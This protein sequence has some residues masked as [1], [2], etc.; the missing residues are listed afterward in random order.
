MAK[1]SYG[2]LTRLYYTVYSKLERHFLLVWYQ[3]STSECNQG[4]IILVL[5]I[6][7]SESKTSLTFAGGFVL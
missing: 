5:V 7:D 4:I 2:K 1:R 6:T 3:H